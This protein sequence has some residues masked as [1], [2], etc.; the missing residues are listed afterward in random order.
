MTERKLDVLEIPGIRSLYGLRP[1]RVTTARPLEAG[2]LA[3]SGT[4]TRFGPRTV[5]GY[6]L[7][8]WTPRRMFQYGLSRYVKFSTD[9]P[10]TR[11]T[12]PSRHVSA[13]SRMEVPLLF[14]H[15]LARRISL[16]STLPLTLGICGSV[17]QAAATADAVSDPIAITGSTPG[18][19]S[20]VEVSVVPPFGVG[21]S[22]DSYALFPLPEADVHISGDEFE[23][24][25][26]PTS[27]PLQYFGSEGLVDFD[28]YAEGDETGWVSSTTARA[29]R[30][31]ADPDPVWVDPVESS[32]YLPAAEPSP[33]PRGGI[34]SVVPTLDD[35]ELNEP[36]FE[37]DG[38]SSNQFAEATYEK[39]SCFYVPNEATRVR[40]T[41]IGTSYTVGDNSTAY[42]DIS[43]NLG[44]T[45][46]V[47]FKAAADGAE[48]VAD[49]SKFVK[50][51]WGKTW[52][53]YNGSR[54]YR[55]DIEYRS[56]DYTCGGITIGQ[57]WRP[58]TETGGTGHNNGITR[59]N[60]TKCVNVDTGP[61]WRQN[62]DG[63]AYSY[64]AAVKFA[65][66]IGIDLSASRQ[67]SSTQRLTYVVAGNDKK[68]CGNDDHWPAKAGKIMMKW[69]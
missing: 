58:T 41:T 42:L 26:D 21:Q 23:V 19:I 14:S 59:P 54:S 68:L 25:I 56:Y 67:Y 20:S 55:K 6:V 15:V 49:G 60:W 12:V 45:Y 38:V 1:T 35:E 39:G 43:S 16:F 3:D 30:L 4:D 50:S 44:G 61:W 5:S 17:S 10:P 47:A 22:E 40:S 66:V 8:Y 57:A 69:Q 52:D 62:D 11:G 32:P 36:E 64:G 63:Y 29:V 28:V 24:F 46:G 18:P 33:S 34:S 7:R 2:D 65:S 37:D 9:L 31:A 13:A 27:I 51:G 48:F 53:P